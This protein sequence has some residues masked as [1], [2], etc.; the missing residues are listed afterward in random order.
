VDYQIMLW[1][2]DGSGFSERDRLL[3][4]MVR[5]HLVAIRDATFK[6]EGEPPPLTS[7]QR[8]LVSLIAAG[9]TNR[10]IARATSAYR[11]T[12]CASTSR[13]SSNASKLTAGPLR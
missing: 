5:P 6:R 8:Q 7:R 3:L 11:S 9:L 13:T 12:R 4:T 1:R 2:A 10:Q